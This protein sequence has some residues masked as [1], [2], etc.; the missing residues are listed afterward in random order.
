MP[1]LKARVG[2]SLDQRSN[3][4]SFR[5]GTESQVENDVQSRE[6]GHQDSNS[7]SS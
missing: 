6:Q 4:W 7:F 5:D 1:Q 3:N 2:G